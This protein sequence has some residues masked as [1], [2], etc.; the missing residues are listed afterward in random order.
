MKKLHRKTIAGEDI[1]RAAEINNAMISEHGGERMAEDL[2]VDA[3]SIM[4]HAT[5]IA[6]SQASAAVA[7]GVG[8]FAGI[9]AVA[10][11]SE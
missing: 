1:Q 9:R 6:E 11:A 7:C 3:R 4:V 10:L 5:A 2:G 8:I